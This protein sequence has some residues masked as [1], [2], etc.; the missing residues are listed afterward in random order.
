MKKINI[1]QLFNDDCQFI[2]GAHNI[3]Q[4]PIHNYP[5][6]AFVGASNVGKS[7]LINAIVNKRIAITSKTPGRTRQLNFFNLCDQIM[8]VDMPGFGYARASKK[9]IANWQ[10]VSFEYLT[11]RSNL[12]RIFL[13]IDP[14]KGLTKHDQ[15]AINIFNALAVGFQIIITKIDKIKNDE[16]LKIITKIEISGQKWPALYPKIITASSLQKIGIDKIQEA[17][18]E[19]I[20]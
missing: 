12:K 3:G 8:L 9:E 10:K 1:K 17:I 11:S 13:L 2:A 6:I 20:K 4:I 19:I 18:F 5:E 14:I 7:S 16:L 15:E